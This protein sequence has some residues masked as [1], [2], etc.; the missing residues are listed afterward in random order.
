[1]C[2]FVCGEGSK[3]GEMRNICNTVEKKKIFLKRERENTMFELQ[4]YVLKI[5]SF[6]LPGMIIRTEE[7][8]NAT[9]RI[10]DSH[11]YGH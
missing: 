6:L 10:L 9:S 4:H 5:E 7:I 8:N 1:M 11:S 3:E 2:V